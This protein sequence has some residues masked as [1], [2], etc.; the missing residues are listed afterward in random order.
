[1]GGTMTLAQSMANGLGVKGQDRELGR[2]HGE[3]GAPF[4]CPDGSDL[5]SYALG[6]ASGRAD[7]RMR[8]GAQPLAAE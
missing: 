5:L 4:D 6:F 1:M 2:R 7:L 8:A 3:T